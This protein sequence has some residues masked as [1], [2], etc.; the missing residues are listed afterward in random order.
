MKNYL[1]QYLILFGLCFTQKVWH[2]VWFPR[3][4]FINER[5]ATF[6]Y[7]RVSPLDALSLLLYSL[8]QLCVCQASV[9]RSLE[10][11]EN[12]Q[13]FQVDR[14]LRK[15]VRIILSSWS[16]EEINLLILIWRWIVMFSLRYLY[17]ILIFHIQ[18][19]RYLKKKNNF[20]HDIRVWVQ[21]WCWCWRLS[22]YESQWRPTAKTFFILYMKKYTHEFAKTCITNIILF[23]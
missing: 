4:Y 13:K 20:C 21:T 14:W 17:F 12:G 8:S 7:D 22:V 19:P 23:T 16:T 5:G 9:V 1:V 11:L 2:N 18:M 3:S 15:E 6:A 10:E